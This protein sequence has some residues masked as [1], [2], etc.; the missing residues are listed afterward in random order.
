MLRKDVSF[1]QTSHLGRRVRS[2]SIG[3]SLLWLGLSIVFLVAAPKVRRVLI[4]MGMNPIPPL[5]RMLVMPPTWP[6]ALL[7]L[8]LAIFT[9]AKDQF[10]RTRWMNM[11][12]L[13]LCIA[14]FLLLM[15]AMTIP[16]YGPITLVG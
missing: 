3:I 1:G 12:I 15:I 5:T 7:C 10:A 14:I 8:I 11:M 4:E 6:A 16:G 9:I 2:F 13:V